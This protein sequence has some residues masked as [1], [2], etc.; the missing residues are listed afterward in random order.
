VQN[1]VEPPVLISRV[2]IFVL[3]AAMVVLAVLFVTLYNMF[4]LNRPQIF[5]LETAVR[6]D[7]YVKLVEMPPE[8][9][10]LDDY[11]K[12]FVREYIRHRN[13][14]VTDIETMT[15]KWNAVDGDVYTMSSDD[16]YANFTK[17]AMF[18]AMMGGGMPNFD[19][20]CPVIFE[21]APMPMPAE[22]GRD[23]SM[24]TFLVK[25]NYFCADSTGRTPEKGYTIKIRIQ[26]DEGTK[27]KWADRIEN[28]L[29][30]RV[31]EYTVSSGGSDPLDMEFLTTE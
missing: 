28:P 31:V 8:S 12:S 10:S 9:T 18:N 17:T 5:F 2:M 25:F 1:R 26:S 11:K 30:L 20:K 4:P 6:D 16:V 22:D 23:N 13:E 3:A 27:I 7:Q 19:F 29:G 21:N 14:V 24:D 15:K